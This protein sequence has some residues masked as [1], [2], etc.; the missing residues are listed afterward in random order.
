MKV[1]KILFVAAMLIGSM[2]CGKIPSAYRGNFVDKASGVSLNLTSKDGT[3]TFADGRKLQ[4]K[5]DDLNFEALSLGKVGIFVREN[6]QDKDLTDV[7]W[8]NPN[9]A[10]KQNQYG[11]VWYQSE[12]IYTIMDSKQKGKISSIQ[13]VQCA[14]GE[15]MVD[16]NS[17]AIQLGCPAGSPSF[18][19]VRTQ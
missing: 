8:L 7:Y 3:L 13:F 18:D 4:A 9:I 2:S 1:S 6:S 14:E 15:V 10:S 17:K 11:F 12:V 5:A 19:A 16:L